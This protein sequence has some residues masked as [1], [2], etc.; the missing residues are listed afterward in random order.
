[1]SA[2]PTAPLVPR[3]R[4][5]SASRRSRGLEAVGTAAMVASVV[6]LVV[7]AAWPSLLTGTD[8]LT[9]SAD[10]LDAP[11]GDHPF[12]TD[13]LGRDIYARV[14]HGARPVLVAAAGGVTMAAVAG[15]ALGLAA[16]I[17]PR[18]LNSLI[19]RVVD[20]LLALPTLLVAL[21]MI[22][23]LGSG[24]S[25]I[26]IAL[27]I[28]YTPSFA[29]IVEASIRRLRS[30][31]FVHAARLFGSSASRTAAT[32][33][34]PN[35]STEVV[36]MAS[37]ALGW[38]VLT[39]TT[40]SFLNFGVQL[41]NPDWGADLAAGATSLSTSWW[42]SI[43]P[44][45]AITA[46]ILVANFVGDRLVVVL[47]PR[48]TTRRTVLRPL[49]RTVTSRRPSTGSDGTNGARTPVPAIEETTP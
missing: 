11:G 39:A 19:M 34:L 5:R 28:A 48:R 15:I 13:Q 3:V 17:G 43:F 6:V 31:E 33:L 4:V 32:H 26:A 7:L 23:V 46:T 21:I 8:P 29:R 12:G 41:P 45:L 25:S 18:W 27:G 10:I 2:I 40:L 30:I 36:V 14:I 9:G 20:V 35:L 44:G 49:L 16:G 42:L 22:A 1:V 24:V 38:S 37:S 47:D